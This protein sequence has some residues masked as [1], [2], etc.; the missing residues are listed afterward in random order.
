MKTIVCLLMIGL[1]IG[2]GT[3]LAEEKS[4]QPA[5][6]RMKPALL[7]IDVQNQYL[8]MMAEKDRQHAI[9]YINYAIWLFRQHGFPVIRVH[10]TDPKYGPAPGSQGF[11]FPKEINT[12]DDDPQIVKNYGDAFKKTDLDTLLKEKGCNGVFCCGLSAVGCA[13]A[14]YHG[15]KNHDYSTFMIKDALLSHND[16]YTDYVEQ[17]C[18]TVGFA[19]LQVMLDNAEH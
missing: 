3:V 18:D 9:E 4:E 16:V 5:P 12:T 19:A 2:A 15:A 13:L 10:H 6:K 8:P 1:F 11:A 17:I 7:V 14:T